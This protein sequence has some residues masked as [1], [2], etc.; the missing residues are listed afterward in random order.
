MK[1]WLSRPRSHRRKRSL[2]PAAVHVEHG[3][4]PSPPRPLAGEDRLPFLTKLG[5]GSG[6]AVIG[7]LGFAKVLLLAFLVDTVGLAAGL[8]GFLIAASKLYDIV[9]DPVIGTFSDRTRSRW[10]RRRPY[11]LLGGLLSWATFVMLFNPPDISN[12]PVLIAYVLVA[13][14]LYSTAYGVFSVPHTAMPAEM[15]QNYHE[16]TSVMSYRAVFASIGLTGGAYL[17]PTLV[18]HFGGGRAGHGAMG[19]IMGAALMVVSSLCFVSTRARK[20]EEAAAGGSRPS[21][22]EQVRLLTSNK[23]FFFLM[24]SSAAMMMTSNVMN[25]SSLFFVRHVLKAGDA[26]LGNFFL[27]LNITMFSSIPAWLFLSRRFGKRNTY[28][29]GGIVLAAS[30]FSWLFATPTEPYWILLI[31]MIFIGL[32]SSAV[33][34][35]GPAMLPDTMEYYRNTTGLRQEGIFSGIY[36]STEKV[37]TAVSMWLVGAVLGMSGYVAGA[38]A[39]SSASPSAIKAIYFCFAIVPASFVVVSVVAILYY[40]LDEA[41]LKGARVSPAPGP[42]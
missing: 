1:S 25:A 41:T 31:R 8:A 27:V 9:A 40:H 29:F 18:T 17:A 16:R 12:G 13:L 38:G 5:W 42:L 22:P 19:W 14:I 2:H 39:D 35:L 15:T 11:L 7:V 36:A 6:A 21:L 3:Q 32:G 24:L 26:W 20:D 28:V 4:V 23:P 34:V 33:N 37:T 10:G 30:C